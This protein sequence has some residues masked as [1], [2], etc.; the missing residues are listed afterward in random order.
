[1]TRDL[2]V[3]CMST[4]YSL[5]DIEYIINTIIDTKTNC[6]F[7]YSLDYIKK[8]Q[9]D[10]RY[11]GFIAQISAKHNNMTI[12][13]KVDISNNTLIFPK[14]L[15]SN[16]NSMFTN[17]TIS[18]MTYPIENI[19]AEKYE[20]TLDRGEYN[21]RI[22]DLFDI[23]FLLHEN[24]HLINNILLAMT[25]IKVSEDRDTLENLDDFDE[26]IYML[27]TSDIFRYNFTR[28]KEKQYPNSPITLNDI[29]EQFK[30]IDQAI[31][32]YQ[33]FYSTY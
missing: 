28:Y 11:S 2:D 17:K 24:T 19:I 33:I 27:S 12:K 5:K 20:T 18:L 8:A 22:R 4:I 6:F 31:K 7:K 15:H 14:A 29:F 13:I 10:D 25:I 30:V 26:I 21:T 9:D 3:T 32:S 16:L 23:Y 1:M